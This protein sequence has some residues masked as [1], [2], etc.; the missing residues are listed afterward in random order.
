MFNRLFKSLRYGSEHDVPST[1]DPKLHYNCFVESVPSQIRLALYK[2]L[3]HKGQI[4]ISHRLPDG[5]EKG[6]NLY[7]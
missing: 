3:L 2:E 6:S 7:S 5:G 1:Y 4:R